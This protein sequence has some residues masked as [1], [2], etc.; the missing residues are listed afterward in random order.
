M[1]IF[2][3]AWT[4]NSQLTE[5]PGNETIAMP[6]IDQNHFG[7]V[8]SANQSTGDNCDNELQNDISDYE[9]WDTDADDDDQFECYYGPS[10][11]QLPSVPSTPNNGTS[12]S[13]RFRSTLMDSEEF[14]AYWTSNNTAKLP[15]TLQNGIEML[16]KQ[17]DNTIQFI[18][19]CN[20]DGNGWKPFPFV[21]PQQLRTHTSFPLQ[22][23]RHVEQYGRN[24]SKQNHSK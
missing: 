9:D 19:Y 1:S 17:L 7:E 20:D 3:F 22:Y 5:T 18:P 21:S 6:G 2:I 14:D 8:M 15:P 16:A 23:G 10:Q 24:H 4:H 12:S 11:S 13:M